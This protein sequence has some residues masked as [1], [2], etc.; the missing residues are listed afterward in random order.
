MSITIELAP[1]G[2]AVTYDRGKFT[3][4][5]R[6]VV[7]DDAGAR[8][9]IQEIMNSA[10]VQTKVY[11]TYDLGSSADGCITELGAYLGSRLR[12]VSVDFGMVDDGGFV[13]QA[14]VQLD[15][16]IAFV[17]GTPADEKNEGQVGFTAIEF[18]AQ[19]EAVEVWR[20][21][22]ATAIVMPAN[23]AAIAYPTDA[24]IAGNKVD[25]EGEPITAFVHTARLSIRNVISGR[26]S[27]P[28]TY[29]NKRNSVAV[30]FGP[31]T[32]AIDTLLFTGCNISRVGV[33]TYEQTWEFAFDAQYHLRQIAKQLD[34]EVATSPKADTCAMAT[35]T[36]KAHDVPNYARCVFWRQPFPQTADFGSAGVLLGIA[37]T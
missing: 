8:L 16:K 11:S 21:D 19:S 24:D 23:T 37:I 5:A 1:N 12:Q 36:A 13:W 6:Y 14:V 4:S 33:S 32:F 7:K 25:S 18:S 28:F 9:T 35:P 15:A 10:T 27:M 34:G 22:G 20:T 30:T 17:T 26:P 2:V 31:H 3:G 29:L